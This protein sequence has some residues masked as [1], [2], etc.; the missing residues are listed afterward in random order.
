VRIEEGTHALGA[1]AKIAELLEPAP[2]RRNV[3]Q[4]PANS[5]VEDLLELVR[6]EHDSEVKKSS[7]RFR[8]R[9]AVDHGHL[10]L[11][12]VVRLMPDDIRGPPAAVP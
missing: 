5:V 8:D 4:V 7:V 6:R 9:D 10:A 2:D 11:A 12:E 3:E 1:W